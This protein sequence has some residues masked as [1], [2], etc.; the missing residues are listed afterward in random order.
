MRSRVPSAIKQTK[1]LLQNN[2][3]TFVFFSKIVGKYYGDLKINL[4][5]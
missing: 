1:P 3:E 4:S 5:H 2:Y